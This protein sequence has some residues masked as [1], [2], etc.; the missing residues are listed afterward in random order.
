M[1]LL[2]IAF[3]SISQNR[4]ISTFVLSVNSPR[5]AT[6]LPNSLKGFVVYCR[7]VEYSNGVLQSGGYGV[8]KET[9]YVEIEP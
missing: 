4:Y 3:L 2:S 5:V 9:C 7:I 1:R 6:A 8:L